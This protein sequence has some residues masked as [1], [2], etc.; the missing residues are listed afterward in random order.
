ML[1]ALESAGYPAA[2]ALSPDEKLAAFVRRG[3][4]WLRDLERGIENPVTAD[5]GTPP[6][7]NVVWSPSGD[8]IAY[9]SASAGSRE[10]R[11]ADPLDVGTAET[12]FQSENFV[13]PTDWT[14]RYLIYTQFDSETNADVWALPMDA[15]A[16]RTPVPVRSDPFLT[17]FGDVS[18]D[19]GWLAFVSDEAGSIDVWVQASPPGS[20][21]WRVS[22]TQSLPMV[23]STQQPRWSRDG[24]ELYFVS[25]GT[26]RGTVMAA[27]VVMPLRQGAAPVGE[28]KPLFEV[29]VNSYAPWQGMIFYDVSSD[30]Q[31]FLI[32]EVDEGTEPVIT[33]IVNGATR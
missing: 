11:V 28:P 3:N 27:P 18:P 5:G 20:G 2:V 1:T 21:K 8:R 23:G 12:V 30:G 7:T 10:L 15:D 22:D 4:V 6:N 33:I 31:R 9:V 29:R 32:N 16:A 26:G 19:G 24:R 13:S 25:G 17:S 14:D